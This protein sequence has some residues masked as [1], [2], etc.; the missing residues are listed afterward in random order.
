MVGNLLLTIGVIVSPVVFLRAGEKWNAI[1]SVI[2]ILLLLYSEN[3]TD[4]PLI[5]EFLCLFNC[6]Y[7]YRFFRAFHRINPIDGF[8]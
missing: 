1:A 2:F 6:L 5:I 4:T 7:A 8:D 3:S